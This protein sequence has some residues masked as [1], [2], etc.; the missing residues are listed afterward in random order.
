M[1]PSAEMLNINAP[2]AE[3]ILT[4]FLRDE[5]KRMKLMDLE[6]ANDILTAEGEAVDKAAPKKWRQEAAA[7]KA[8]AFRK[9]R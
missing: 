8:A 9:G 2:L 6:F 5:I 7:E 4:N 3:R 1:N